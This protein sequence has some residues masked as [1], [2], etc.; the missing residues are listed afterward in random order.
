VTALDYLRTNEDVKLIMNFPTPYIEERKEYYPWGI[1]SLLGISPSRVVNNDF[2]SALF[3]ENGVVPCLN[4]GNNLITLRKE[5]AKGLEDLPY[6]S[7]GT[8]LMINR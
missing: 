4:H 7:N 6:G 5:L 2:S 1:L 3:I 8:I